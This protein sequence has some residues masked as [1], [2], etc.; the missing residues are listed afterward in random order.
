MKTRLFLHDTLFGYICF[1]YTND[2]NVYPVLL[3]GTNDQMGAGL[4]NFRY[5]NMCVLLNKSVCLATSM[6]LVTYPHS[7][8]TQTWHNNS[9]LPLSSVAWWG[10]FHRGDQPHFYATWET[11]HYDDEPRFP[12][13]R[14]A[15]EVTS[16]ISMHYMELSVGSTIYAWP[17]HSMLLYVT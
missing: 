8:I 17:P 10:T 13:A 11:I 3:T 15:V 1:I 5:N 9:S 16:L 2:M 7:N 4:L 6:Q 12:T 14:D